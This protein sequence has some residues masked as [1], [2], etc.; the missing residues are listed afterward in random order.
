MNSKLTM[1]I[2][3]VLRGKIYHQYHDTYDMEWPKTYYSI[4]RLGLIHC[5]IGFIPTFLN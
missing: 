4:G 5:D 1:E 3:S 2:Y